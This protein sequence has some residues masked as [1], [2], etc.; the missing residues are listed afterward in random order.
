MAQADKVGAVWIFV[1]QVESGDKTKPNSATRVINVT[2]RDGVADLQ[3]WY[4]NLVHVFPQ[5]IKLMVNRQ[6][7]DG[8]LLSGRNVRDCE[9]CCWE[10]QVRKTF[11]QKL[12]RHIVMPK[13][14]QLVD[15]D[16]LV[17]A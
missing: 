1:G 4:K 12:D 14:N 2:A 17:Q 16:L 11:K 15:A 7:V 6:L 13:K 3:L 5:Y 10:K 9:R 8:M